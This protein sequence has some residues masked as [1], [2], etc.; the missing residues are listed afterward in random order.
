MDADINLILWRLNKI[1]M[2]GI[3]TFKRGKGV[4]SRALK[5]FSRLRG[6]TSGTVVSQTADTNTLRYAS[7]LELQDV[8]VPE[9]DRG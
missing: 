5:A 7:A 2:P 9:I 3:V 8:Q 6:R 1:E 4:V